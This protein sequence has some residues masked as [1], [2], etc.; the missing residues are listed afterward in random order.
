ME[1]ALE[2]LSKTELIALISQKD[3]L[4]K[5]RN[6][7]IQKR[8]EVVRIKDEEIRQKQAELISK[9]AEI[10][11]LRRMLFGQKRERFETSSIQLPLDFGQNLSEEDIAALQQAINQKAEKVKEEE[12]KEPRGPH[13]GRS[14]LP[15]HLPVKEIVLEPLEDTTDMVRI[16]Q[17]ISDSLQYEPSRYFIQRIV[18]PKYAPK[19]AAQTIEE[20]VRIAIAELPQSGF[21][22]C[23]AGT[24]VIAQ[25]L[26]DKY[27]DH[28]PL[29][30]QL[31]RFTREGIDIAPATMDHWAKLGMQRL[32]LLYDYQKELILKSNYI[33][34]DETTIKVLD[35]QNKKG[36]R[37]AGRTH[38]GYFW[39]YHDP[40]GKQ[41][42]FQYEKGRGGKYPFQILKDFSGYLQT[43]GYAG[44]EGLAEKQG[45]VHLACWAH[46][47]RKF[48]D[49]ESYDSAMASTALT[50]IQ[51]LY[52]VE[53]Q[54]REKSL[55]TDQTKELRLQ[56]ALPQYNLLGKW[57]S[58]NIS[59][60]LPKSPIGVA[61]RYT[62]ERWDELG[63]Y[64]YDGRLQIDNNLTE[65][66]IRPATI[67]RKNYLFAGSHE[68]AQRAAVMYSFMDQCKRHNI[69]PHQ[70]LTYV[71]EKILDT[72][73][74]QYHSLLPKNF[75]PKKE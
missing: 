47:R 55:D 43:D 50:L 60:V 11:K 10:E 25:I 24:G 1:T 68:G 53:Q 36:H 72:K 28:L 29:Y 20:P 63:H 56:K 23:M 58:A 64:M 3:V 73:P 21:A 44:Y 2:S 39:V 8:E 34:A 52:A 18:R 26:I 17:E 33:Q 40:L 70:W 7:T 62:L 38:L 9:Q 22:K 65:N 59:K 14:P 4:L 27:C 74:S 42:L 49:S 57:I 46:A 5:E 13:P 48:K 15:K 30:R 45:V 19:P 16:G 75:R 32:S 54:A 66:T 12:K 31:Q 6:L 67:G 35:H 69:H 37:I 41:T 51:A 61:M 71:F